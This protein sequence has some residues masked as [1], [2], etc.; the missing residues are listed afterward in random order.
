MRAERRGEQRQQWQGRSDQQ[1]QHW[2][3]QRL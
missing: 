3:R 2:Q 1:R